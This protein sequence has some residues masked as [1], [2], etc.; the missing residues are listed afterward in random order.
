MTAIK[1][2]SLRILTRTFTHPSKS[3]LEHVKNELGWIQVTEISSLPEER[4]IY[5]S[6]CQSII[7]S[8][9]SEDSSY[10]DSLMKNIDSAI[11]HKTSRYSSYNSLILEPLSR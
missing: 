1:M 6:N 5:V 11:R 2:C 8:S 7:F 4:L 10:N 3:R 9:V